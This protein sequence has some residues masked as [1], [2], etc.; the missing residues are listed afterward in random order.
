MK[1]VLNSEVSIVVDF[2]DVPVDAIDV[3]DDKF[4]QLLNEIAEEGAGFFDMDRIKTISKD[5]WVLV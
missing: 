4:R 1:V 5:L 3:I 2:D